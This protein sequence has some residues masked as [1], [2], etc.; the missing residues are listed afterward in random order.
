MIDVEYAEN[1]MHNSKMILP[2][3]LKLSV[4]V[5]IDKTTNIEKLSVFDLTPLKMF[6][7]CFKGF[8][9]RGCFIWTLKNLNG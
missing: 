1:V 2:S 5:D 3:D 8:F 4:S 7:L 9:C 6:Q